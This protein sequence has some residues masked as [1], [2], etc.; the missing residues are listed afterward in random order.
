M[1][2]RISN[3]D[4][5]GFQQLASALFAQTSY[6]ISVG[7]PLRIQFQIFCF[8]FSSDLISDIFSSDIISAL[9]RHLTADLISYFL[10]LVCLFALGKPHVKILPEARLLSPN[11]TLTHGLQIW[12]TGPKAVDS[13]WYFPFLASSHY[14]I[15]LSGHS[16]RAGYWKPSVNRQPAQTF[17]HLLDMLQ[18]LTLCMRINFDQLTWMKLWFWTL[19]GDNLDGRSNCR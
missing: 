4:K 3:C 13:V 11:F 7:I 16:K 10:F 5:A 17:H 14:Q 8:L 1:F 15:S 18:S 2:P 9:P 6:Q 12:Q 19:S